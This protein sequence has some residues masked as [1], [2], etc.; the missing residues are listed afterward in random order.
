MED[1]ELLAQETGRQ[2]ERS[3]RD[4]EHRRREI[5]GQVRKINDTISDAPYFFML[6]YS[7]LSKPWFAT[8]PH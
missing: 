2:T 3:A 5:D 7:S 8:N 4:K 1:M 6:N